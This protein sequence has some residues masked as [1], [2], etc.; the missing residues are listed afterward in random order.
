SSDIYHPFQDLYIAGL[1]GVIERDAERGV[2]LQRFRR[3]HDSLAHA[4][5]QLPD[6]PLFFIHPA[7][8]TFIRRQRTRTPFLQYQRIPVGEY[9][10][11][12]PY[13]PTV[14]QI[15]QQLAKIDDG[16]FVD[17]AHQVVMRIQSLLNSKNTPFARVEIETSEDWQLLWAE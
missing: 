13:F 7:L 17:R 8:D 12:E 15:E 2:S 4:A 10:L 3:P 14:M 6:S 5:T 9:L 1:L 11:W 16:Q